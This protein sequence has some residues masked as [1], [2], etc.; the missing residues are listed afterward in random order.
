MLTNVYNKLRA[1]YA[2][3]IKHNCP[4]YDIRRMNDL[5]K[6]HFEMVLLCITST[7]QRRNLFEKRGSFKISP[8][9]HNDIF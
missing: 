7:K 4:C 1:I 9:C 6:F 8:S 5:H 2:T 3:T